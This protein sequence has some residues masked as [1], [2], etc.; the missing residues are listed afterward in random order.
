MEVN[1]LWLRT[2]LASAMASVRT[3]LLNCGVR[4]HPK[5]SSENRV[6]PSHFLT[7]IRIL[8]D[9]VHVVPDRQI[10]EQTDTHT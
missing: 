9:P 6:L 2:S 7:V 3:E 4:I 10:D 5:S 8:E 1:F